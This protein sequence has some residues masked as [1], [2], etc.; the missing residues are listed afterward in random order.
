MSVSRQSVCSSSH[1][2][3]NANITKHCSHNDFRLTKLLHLFLPAAFHVFAGFRKRLQTLDLPHTASYLNHFGH[4]F[5]SRKYLLLSC[6]RLVSHPLMLS[7]FQHHPRQQHQLTS[8]PLSTVSVSS[9]RISLHQRGTQK[10]TSVSTITVMPLPL[11]HHVPLYDL[12]GVAS[13][14]SPYSKPPANFLLHFSMRQLFVSWHGSIP[15]PV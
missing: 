14:V 13:A 15:A 7:I 12:G 9:D 6:K 10:L 11:P 5:L 4:S 3:H 2:S 8:Q 1:E